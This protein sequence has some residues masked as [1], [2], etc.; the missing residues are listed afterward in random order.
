METL[1]VFFGIS[2]II[3]KPTNLGKINEY[4]IEPLSKV[5]NVDII[6]VFIEDPSNIRS[7]IDNEE[8]DALHFIMHGL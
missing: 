8:Y 1:K 2:P 7:Y 3:Y 6:H 4:I 5:E